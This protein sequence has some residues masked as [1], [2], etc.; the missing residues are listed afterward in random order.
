MENAESN[1]RLSDTGIVPFSIIMP[2][3]N[4]AAWVCRAIL[5]IFNQSHAA[6]EL[7]IVDDGSEDD[8]Y[9]LIENFLNDDRISYCR[10]EYNEG[11]GVAL[12]KGLDMA[13][14]DYIAYLPA[15]DY[16]FKNHLSMLALSLKSASDIVLSFSGLQYEPRMVG[17]YKIDSNFI[18][19][20]YGLQLVQVA[21][22]KTEDRWM[23]RAELVT[24]DLFIMFWKKL[25]DKGSFMPT[26][27]TTCYW[28]QHPLQRHKLIGEKYGGGINAYKSFYKINKPL[29]FRMS[30]YKSINEAL[31]YKDLGRNY[32][33]MSTYKL[34]V[35]LV[36]ELGYNPERICALEEQGCELYG[37]W[38]NIPQLPFANIGYFPFG[39]IVNISYEN[40]KERVKEINPDIIYALGNWDSIDLAYEVLMEGLNIP[41]IWHFKESPFWA[42]S[43][44]L[45]NK[46][47]YLY[48]KSDGRIFI[49]KQIKDWYNLFFYVSEP[50]FIM[51]LDMPIK[52]NNDYTNSQKLSIKCNE[53]HTVITGRM[54]GI[55]LTD[56]KVL[57]E[58]NIHIHLY[59]END[60]DLRNYQYKNYKDIA[61]NHFHFHNH[62]PRNKWVEEFSKYDAGWLHCFDSENEGDILRLSWDDLNIPARIYTAMIAGIPTIQKDN[63]GHI[64]AI[65]DIVKNTDTGFFYKSIYDLS[66]KLHDKKLLLT[67]TN[68]VKK[69]RKQF[70]FDYYVIPLKNFFYKVIEIKKYRTNY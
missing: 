46:L 60:H 19:K 52:R 37:L 65:Q 43:Q 64:V 8:T 12:N 4:N 5:S 68:N 15:D 6:W 24:D 50:F 47:L 58:N 61:R 29:K 34:K 70:M 3:Y 48:R 54:Q 45:W 57:S 32:S 1:F 55:S 23:E 66:K 11:L 63:S 31:L 28:T 44:N 67:L 59:A 7:I 33:P 69:H 62:V 35:L 42:L 25:A 38:I 56:M 22:K 17:H 20:G 49:N 40:W 27:H 18:R 51:D 41:F 13:K 30:K 53:I 21:H 26:F 39:N 9:S 10:N 36:G 2:V 14:Y 16:Y